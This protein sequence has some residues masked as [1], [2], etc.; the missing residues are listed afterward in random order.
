MRRG[1]DTGLGERGP[2]QQDGTYAGAV[3]TGRAVGGRV[4]GRKDAELAVAVKTLFL[5]VLRGLQE[6]LVCSRGL[7]EQRGWVFTEYVLLVVFFA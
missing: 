6:H 4:A 7:G 3:G 1:L 2:K 5:H